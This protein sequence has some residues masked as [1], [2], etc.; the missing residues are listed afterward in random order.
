[1]W[2]SVEIWTNWKTLQNAHCISCFWIPQMITNRKFL[3]KL[4]AMVEIPKT[5]EGYGGNFRCAPF[6]S[7]QFAMP[8]VDRFLECFQNDQKHWRKIMNRTLSDFFWKSDVVF[9]KNQTF[10]L[11]AICVFLPLLCVVCN[12]QLRAYSFIRF[13]SLWSN[14][15][16]NIQQNR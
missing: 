14:C 11:C 12:F 10:L 7:G 4:G 5:A 3:K 9:L 1:M 8:N 2:S 6:W 13:P 15:C 16:D